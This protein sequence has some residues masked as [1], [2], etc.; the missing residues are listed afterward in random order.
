MQTRSIALSALLLSV[1]MLSA[2]GNADIDNRSTVTVD[3]SHDTST[4]PSWQDTTAPDLEYQDYQI[5]AGALVTDCD[6]RHAIYEQSLAQEY[7]SEAFGILDMETGEHF[8]VLGEAINSQRKYSMFSPRIGEGWIAWEEVSPN[9][10]SDPNNAEWRLYAAALDVEN[11]QIGYPVLVDSGNTSIVA[12]PFYGLSGSRLIWS[13]NLRPRS[14]QESSAHHSRLMSRDLT[15]GAEEVILESTRNWIA[16]CV[17]ELTTTIIEDPEPEE[18]GERIVVADSRTGDVRYSAQLP[19][20]H[21][22]SHF[23]RAVDGAVLYDA[24]TNPNEPWPNL[25]VIS[26]DDPPE[27][28][29]ANSMDPVPFGPW[30]LYEQVVS[31]GPA[32]HREEVSRLCGMSPATREVFVLDETETGLWQTPLRVSPD[33]TQTLIAVTLYLSPWVENQDTPHEIV[34][35]YRLPGR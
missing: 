20:N 33:T 23:A 1:L 24:F 31:T 4:P 35:V 11:R 2:C 13:R 12:R 15:H 17:S 14:V 34:R 7:P 3:R 8:E 21:N 32:G 18:R 19:K 28:V 9:E 16:V 6:D 27:S 10:S 30:L 26:E 29:R 22:T 25:Y 5:P